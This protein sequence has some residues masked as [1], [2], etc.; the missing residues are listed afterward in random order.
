MSVYFF[1]NRICKC[2]LFKSS[3]KN[4]NAIANESQ[5][6]LKFKF[7]LFWRETGMLVTFQNADP[8]AITAISLQG[9]FVK[10]GRHPFKQMQH[11]NETAVTLPKGGA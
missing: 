10:E 4:F 1:S 8:R 3:D 5:Y 11:R 2:V 6:H 9:A 7:K